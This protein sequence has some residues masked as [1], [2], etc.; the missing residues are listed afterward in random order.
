[1]PYF[2]AAR[3]ARSR[4]FGPYGPPLLRIGRGSASA[5]IEPAPALLP[6]PSGQAVSPARYAS[7]A[8]AHRPFGRALATPRRL[9]WCVCLPAFRILPGEEGGK[10]LRFQ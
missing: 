10:S 5:G 9:Y 6:R 1:M 8:Y 4:R 7:L 3:P 2:A